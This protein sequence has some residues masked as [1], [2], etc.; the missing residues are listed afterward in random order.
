MYLDNS[1]LNR[2][3]DDPT[4]DRN[5]FEAD[6]V[7]TVMRLIDNGTAELV[8]SEAID[9]EADQCRELRRR[10]A[11]DAARRAHRQ[12]IR[13]GQRE[14][15]RTLELVDIGFKVM[16]AAHIASAESGLCDVL[17]TTDDRMIRRAERLGTRLKVRV[18]NPL[19][20]VREVRKP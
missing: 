8:W 14:R 1:S 18:I 3:Q 15:A 6:A 11:V 7:L 16:D 9:L 2:Q 17:L 19:D 12:Y 13:I 5:Q 4:I 20:W 10:E